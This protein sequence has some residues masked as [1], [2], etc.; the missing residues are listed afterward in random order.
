M[1]ERID[2][3][4]FFIETKE[5]ITHDLYRLINPHLMTFFKSGKTYLALTVDGD[6]LSVNM[7]IGGGD[8]GVFYRD[9]G[10][11]ASRIGLRYVKFQTSEKNK[12]VIRIAEYYKAKQV[13]TY[14]NFYNG[15]EDALEFVIDIK[16]SPRVT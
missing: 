7:A 4:H 5:R 10:R 3:P 2:F 11:E 14:P 8:G 12:A 16:T 13:N 1:L 9:L 15:D 6:T